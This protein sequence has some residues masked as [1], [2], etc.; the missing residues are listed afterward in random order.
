MGTPGGVHACKL[1]FQK[2]LTVK[3][4]NVDADWPFGG[5]N[6]FTC[7]HPA[8]NGMGLLHLYGVPMMVS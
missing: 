8:V 5:E 6:T 1:R 4:Q 7:D 2:K 3:E